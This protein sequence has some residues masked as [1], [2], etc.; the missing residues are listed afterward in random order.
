MRTKL[1]TI[2]LALTVG[3][4]ATTASAQDMLPKDNGT[5]T[6]FKAPRWRESESH[7]LRTFAYV[8][9]PVG[10][11]LREGFFRPL[12]AFT[13]S[14][15]F[16]RSFFGYREPFDYREGVCFSTSGN[17]PDCRTVSPYINI[18]GANLAT[19]D[20]LNFPDEQVEE[21]AMVDG[22]ERQ[23][24][25]PDVNFEFDKA[26][27]TDLGKG[28]VRQVAQLLTSIPSLT[29]VVEGHTDFKGSDEYNVSLG[30]RRAQSVVDELVALG[31]DPAR[32]N[33]VSLGESKPIFTEEEDWSRAINRRI[34]FSVQGAQDAGADMAMM[35]EET[36]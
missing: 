28:R 22:G 34:Q 24:F 8:L 20:G 13:A 27:L 1:L 4:V 7:P 23:V 32:L 9:H 25:F 35:E 5:A 17:V 16:T 2:G 3:V 26:G 36:E 21:A 11:V 30:E 31:V 12:S 6:Y 10:W 33:P 18:N 29:V 14:T 19:V 15:A